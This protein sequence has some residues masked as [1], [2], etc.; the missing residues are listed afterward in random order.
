MYAIKYGFIFPKK[1]IKLCQI[2]VVE[3]YPL[4]IKIIEA[5]ISRTHFRCSSEI[6]RSLMYQLLNVR[7]V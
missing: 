6:I 4:A 1:Y 2:P 5:P 7:A 3:L